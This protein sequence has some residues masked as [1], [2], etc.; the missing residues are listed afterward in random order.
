MVKSSGSGLAQRRAHSDLPGFVRTTIVR[1]NC[2]LSRIAR[3][4]TLNTEL[5][6]VH[7]TAEMRRIIGFPR[8]VWYSCWWDVHY[9]DV[10]CS[11][12][13]RRTGLTSTARPTRVPLDPPQTVTWHLKEPCKPLASGLLWRCWY[14]ASWH[15]ST[16]H[17]S[18]LHFHKLFLDHHDLR[19]QVKTESRVSP[20][21][22]I[23]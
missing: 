11:P 19:L 3:R 16:N 13:P 23:H 20:P 2:G 15:S 10:T 1:G 22:P 6:G 5:L 14:N 12:P 9:G 17:T 7:N 4:R 18:P 21:Y 8:L